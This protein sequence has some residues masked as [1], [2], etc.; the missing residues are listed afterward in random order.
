M[1]EDDGELRGALEDGGGARLRGGPCEDS[2]TLSPQLHCSTG[3]SLGRVG[4]SWGDQGVSGE[5]ASSFLAVSSTAWPKG[6][7]NSL[8]SV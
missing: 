1:P 3:S 4:L 8:A 5:A 6:P 2:T 7:Q